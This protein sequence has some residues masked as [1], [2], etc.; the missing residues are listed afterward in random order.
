MKTTQQI[1]GLSILSLA[2]AAGSAYAQSAPGTGASA[3]ASTA[4][5][6]SPKTREQVRQELFAAERNGETKIGFV[7]ISRGELDPDRYPVAEQARYARAHASVQNRAT[8]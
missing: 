4:S 2:L 3:T 1:L 5:P 8:Q 6:S 7:A